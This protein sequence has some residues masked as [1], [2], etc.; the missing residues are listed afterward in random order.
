MKK[1]LYFLAFLMCFLGALNT[2]KAQTTVTIGS[3]STAATNSGIPFDLWG[4]KNICQQLFLE[5]EISHTGGT[6]NSIAIKFKGDGSSS[7]YSR[8]VAIYI[9]STELQSLN[10]GQNISSDQTPNFDGTVTFAPEEWIEFVFTTPFIYTGGNIIVTMYDY[11]GSSSGNGYYNFYVNDVAEGRVVFINNYQGNVTNFASY[12]S[13]KSVQRNIMKLTFEGGTAQPQTQV[14]EIGSEEIKTNYDF[15]T[16]IYYNYSLTQ[17]I[18][19]SAEIGINKDLSVKSIAF[20]NI[21]E[22]SATRN[23]EIYMRNTTSSSCESTSVAM[24]SN[25]LVYSG[26][27]NFVASDWTAITFQTPFEYKKGENVLLCVVDKT[28]SFIGNLPF[29][30]Y[31]SSG[32]SYYYRSD[33]YQQYAVNSNNGSGVVSYRNYIKLEYEERVTPL[34]LSVSAEKEIVYTGETVQLTA[35]ASGGAGNYTYSWSPATGLN[36]TTSATPTFTPT[37]AGTYNIT[38]E[39]TSATETA[40][41]NVT[42]VVNERPVAPSAPTNLQATVNGTS[43]TLTWEDVSG[44]TSYNVYINNGSP[45]QTTDPT[46]TVTGLNPATNYCFTVTAVNIGGESSPSD[47]V[48]VDT[49]EIK[50]YR[51]KSVDYE[52]KYLNIA[53]ITN[54]NTGGKSGV[55]VAAYAESDNQIFTIE[56]AGYGNV[57]F[58]SASG[59]YINCLNEW[60]VSAHGTT[61]SSAA[62]LKMVDKGNNTFAIQCND[63]YFKVEEVSGGVYPF[64]N[65]NSSQAALWTLEEVGSSSTEGCEVIFELKAAGDYGWGSDGMFVVYYTGGSEN[66]DNLTL[67]SGTSKTYTYTWA[68]GTKLTVILCTSQYPAEMGYTIKYANGVVIAEKEIGEISS[69]D[70]YSSPLYLYEIDCSELPVPTV[71]AVAVGKSAIK[72]T[73]DELGG[74]TGYNVYDE[75]GNLLI[76]NYPLT[77]YTVSDLDATTEYCF[78][79]TAIFNEEESEHSDPACATTSN[80]DTTTGIIGDGEDALG[81]GYALP[82][83]VYQSYSYSQQS[84]TKDEIAEAGGYEGFITSIAYKV[85]SV[86]STVNTRKLRV[87]MTNISSENEVVFNNYN[88][89]T[90]LL[91]SQDSPVFEGPITF[92]KE[93]DGWVEISFTTPFYYGGNHILVTVID[94]TGDTDGNDIE[95]YTHNKYSDYTTS[96]TSN[97]SGSNKF[98]PTTLSGYVNLYR[99]NIKLTFTSP[100]ADIVF[101]G[102]G[103]WNNTANWNLRRLP[104]GS[105]DITITGDAVLTDDKTV[106]SITIDGGSL[107]IGNGGILTVGGNITHNS[108]EA[109][110]LKDGGQL[111]QNNADLQ[112]TFVMKINKPEDWNEWNKTGWQFI[113]SPFTNAAVS[114]FTSADTYD[115]YK[116]DG[117]H[118][119]IA[120]EWRNHKDAT[121]NF[122]TEFVSGRGYMASYKNDT[123]ATLSG[124]FNNAT[125]ISYPVTYQ[126]INEG[127]TH[128]PNFHLLGNPFTFNMDLSNL[129]M[130]NMATGVAMVNDGGTYDYLT[131]T[132]DNTIK[133]GDGFF[134]KS[135]AA[136][137]SVSYGVATR[138]SNDDN[139]SENISVRVSNNATRDNVVLNFAGSD[140]AGFPKL[141]AFNE[142][143]AYLYVVSE[144]Q[145][146]GIFNYDKDVN[147]VSLSFEAQK[148]GKYT[149]SVDAEGEYETIVLVDRQTGIETNML[150]EDYSFTATSSSKEN[151]DRF[152]VRF[153]FR[154]DVNE[155]AKHFAYQSGDELIIEAEG[156]V[157]LFDVTGRMLYIGEVE[158]HGE[159]INVGH[160]NNAAYILRLVNEEGVKVQKVIIY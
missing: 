15:P 72:L 134:V 56:D 46:Y 92:T 95:F 47:K 33:S 116:F 109:L 120:K 117:R 67:S 126:D 102:N 129:N 28:G 25:E 24:K 59:Y 12:T 27:V 131:L 160:L 44:A 23:I 48:C 101:D 61:T 111:F 16:N 68:P 1:K 125:S 54:E 13:T 45:I 130:T 37:T 152:L 78:T 104:Y 82:I 84:Y 136:D 128:W 3:E 157:Q 32:D 137:P 57:Y 124:T 93:G 49:D 40:T 122:E 66:G 121:A 143:A 148:M 106:E 22:T 99:N 83:A 135:T 2:M 159:R 55:D 29:A 10:T 147:E 60:M 30:V 43:V 19:T 139:T 145:R 140:K 63:G 80:T 90:Y 77:T 42:I 144:E 70:N 51:I 5:N 105:E 65:G 73:W 141:N 6:I 133:V 149:I 154:S 17:Q 52:G 138:G 155:E 132:S 31:I 96:W 69:S 150:L 21:S 100:Y 119:N 94:D 142:D 64:S 87:Y 18:Y 156:T 103:N 26:E 39:V 8:K 14:I 79:V 118:E 112:G 7:T 85:Y 74:A 151:T 146:Y 127:E 98:E 114:Q 4:S 38:C 113:A 53:Q 108:A 91:S 20:K 71:N 123:T 11:T 158:S 89:P 86:K 97:N 76:G 107:T 41:D 36:N 153:T 9:N 88:N 110:V 81:S 35:T 58:R 75:D 62:F 34:S 50:R 115:L